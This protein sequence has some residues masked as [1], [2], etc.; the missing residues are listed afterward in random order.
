MGKIWEEFLQAFLLLLSPRDPSVK[1]LLWLS[2]CISLW[3]QKIWLGSLGRGITTA[4]SK[5]FL[6]SGSWAQCH[7]PSLCQL[8]KYHQ[9]QVSNWPPRRT[10][11]TVS[12]DKTWTKV[13][14][15]AFIHPYC[16]DSSEMKTTGISKDR[17]AAKVEYRPFTLCQSNKHQTRQDISIINLPPS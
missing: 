2:K 11:N 14:H 12:E 13:P 5:L 3:G 9:F 16:W 6:S 10:H 17:C 7:V 4:E 8:R 15:T 1:S